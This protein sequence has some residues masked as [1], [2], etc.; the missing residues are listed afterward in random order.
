[1]ETQ[2]PRITKTTLNSKRTAG[3]LSIPVLN[4]HNRWILMIQHGTG[5]TTI[6]EIE[7]RTWTQVHTSMNN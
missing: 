7:L 2:K 1:M 6:R 5:R 3:G 4:L